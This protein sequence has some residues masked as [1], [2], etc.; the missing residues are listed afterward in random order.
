MQEYLRWENCTFSYGWFSP[1]AYWEFRIL[2]NYANPQNNSYIYSNKNWFSQTFILHYWDSII[3]EGNVRYFLRNQHRGLTGEEFRLYNFNPIIMGA[4]GLIYDGAE[5]M[6][7]RRNPFQWRFTR[8]FWET[9]T[10]QTI[11]GGNLNN[12]NDQVLLN[13]ANIGSDYLQEVEYMPFTNGNRIDYNIL[14][15]NLGVP[16]NRIYMGRL[17]NRLE[18]RRINEWVSSNEETLMNL[19]LQAWFGKGYKDWYNQH[20]KYS[21]QNIMQNFIKVNTIQTNKVISYAINGNNITI[22]PNIVSEFKD[23]SF[24]DITLLAH[25][26]D[27]TMTKMFYLGIQNRRTDPLV[28]LS[29]EDTLSI[30]TNSGEFRSGFNFIPTARF[31]ELVDGADSNFWRSKWLTRLGTR[32]IVLPFNY[33][34]LQSPTSEHILHVTELRDSSSFN[35]NWAWWRQEKWKRGI[36]TIISDSSTIELTLLPGEGKILKV[37]ILPKIKFSGELPYSAQNKMV[38]YPTKQQ[39]QKD[40]SYKDTSVYYHIT[41]QKYDTVQQAYNIYY[42]RSMPTS[43]SHRGTNIIWEPNEYQISKI[44]RITNAVE[45]GIET[46]M[47]EGMQQGCDCKYPTIVVRYDSIAAEAMAYIVYNCRRIMSADSMKNYIVETVFPANYIGTPTIPDT[48]NVI[49]FAY[50]GNPDDSLKRWGVP[51]INGSYSMNYYAWADSI[52]GIMVG[53]KTPHDRGPITTQNGISGNESVNKN[54]H[55]NLNTYSRMQVNEETCSIVWQTEGPTNN[56]IYYTRLREQNGQIIPSIYRDAI[57]ESE[58]NFKKAIRIPAWAPTKALINFPYQGIRPSFPS[59]HRNISYKLRAGSEAEDSIHFAKNCWDRIVWMYGDEIEI[60]NYLGIKA[61]DYS[62]SLQK[63]NYL[64]TSYIHSINNKLIHP[65]LTQGNISYESGQFHDMIGSDSSIVLF[66]SEKSNSNILNVYQLNMSFWS[67]F[68]YPTNWNWGT[69]NLVIQNTDSVN[70]SYLHFYGNGMYP[71]P[72]SSPVTNRQQDFWLTRGVYQNEDLMIE[73]ASPKLSFKGTENQ[74]V[75]KYF[76]GF[77][78]PDSS[79]SS[80]ISPFYTDEG[81]EIPL[82]YGVFNNE[83]KLKVYDTLQTD[84]FKISELK[85]IGFN[86]HSLYAK[87]MSLYLQR[88]EDGKIFSLTPYLQSRKV[89]KNIFTFLNGKNKKYRLLASK[90]NSL[91]SLVQ[92]IIIGS[93]SE[94]VSKNNL[95]GDEQN[96]KFASENPHIINLGPDEYDANKINIEVYPIPVRDELYFVAYLPS[97]ELKLNPYSQL[98]IKIYSLLGEEKF[99]TVVNSGD[100]HKINTSFLPKG[101]YIL[102]AIFY[103]SNKPLL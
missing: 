100:V 98:N 20:P 50:R 82:M 69:R 63:E 79:Q 10:I 103:G 53:V 13:D 49:A 73:G 8:L 95:E 85:K 54:L 52:R 92:N 36:D 16:R 9:D 43:A 5:D 46:E 47:Y 30:N 34:N 48:S 80:S 45:P 67:L 81:K 94:F 22:T 28:V 66:F 4:K 1:L 39:N 101:G 62:D 15:A 61:V 12:I 44:R 96:Y 2:R 18:L 24:Y 102:R 55:P 7:D 60:D 41:Y 19:K 86:F 77:S 84:W 51:T 38:V 6:K 35:S 29:P 56:Y 68:Q 17:S 65:F 83:G 21:Q 58:P 91:N 11:Y 76:I 31:D 87:T 71:H 72:S 37:E 59:V 70:Q 97:T 64:P 93:E 27:T 25:N 99:S 26:T 14:E 78:S 33:S 3:V 32:Q 23:S 40:F 89:K 57:D 88:Q 74:K 75:V 90:N 42:R